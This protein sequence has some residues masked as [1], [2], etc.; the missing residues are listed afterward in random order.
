M[1]HMQ[2]DGE[3]YEQACKRWDRWEAWNAQADAIERAWAPSPMKGLRA[4]WDCG[5]NFRQAINCGREPN[6][7]CPRRE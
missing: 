4:G 3:T 1:V 5:C 7:F 6:P 2:Y